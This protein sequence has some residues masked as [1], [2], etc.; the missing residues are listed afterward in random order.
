MYNDSGVILLAP[1]ARLL[2]LAKKTVVC[3][4]NDLRGY[5]H[6]SV[7]HALDRG[8]H[9]GEHG[10]LAITQA[11]RLAISANGGISGIATTKKHCAE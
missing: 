3:A 1:V 4:R 6:R 10:P 8:R 2:C 5:V 9:G 11:A 7:L